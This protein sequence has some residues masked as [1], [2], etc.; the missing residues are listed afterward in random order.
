MRRRRRFTA[1]A[2]PCKQARS[3]RAAA[4]EC[5]VPFPRISA[6]G[7][8]AGGC[9]GL[10]PVGHARRTTRPS[11]RGDAGDAPARGD[12]RDTRP[13]CPC[14]RPRAGTGSRAGHPGPVGG[15]CTGSATGHARTGP[16][17]AGPHRARR[18]RDDTGTCPRSRDGTGIQDRATRSPALSLPPAACMIDSGRH[19]RAGR[20]ADR[21]S[22]TSGALPMPYAR[23]Q[24]LRAHAMPQTHDTFHRSRHAPGSSR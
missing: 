1:A 24:A 22:L 17:R 10:C 15:T 12:A 19:A 11:S 18:A 4:K 9:A 5:H 7:N 13:A 6:F 20:A 3:S 14:P 8:P 21:P 2:S 16:R 23:A